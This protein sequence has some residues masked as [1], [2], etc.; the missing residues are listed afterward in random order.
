LPPVWRGKVNQRRAEIPAQRFGEPQEFGK[1][2]TFLCSS[3]AGYITGQ[4]L[5]IDG[6]AYPGIL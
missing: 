1:A 5:V 4:S 3:H 2:C 6:G